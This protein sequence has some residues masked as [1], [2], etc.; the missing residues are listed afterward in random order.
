MDLGQRATPSLCFLFLSIIVSRGTFI[1]IHNFIYTKLAD[2]M[3][4]S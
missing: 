2:E 1:D 3:E 4:L